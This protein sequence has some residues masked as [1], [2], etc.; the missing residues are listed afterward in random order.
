M[1][2]NYFPLLT[3]L[4]VWGPARVP[5]QPKVRPAPC[6]KATWARDPGGKR[7]GGPEQTLSL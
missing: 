6:P 3:G 4:R 5:L 2:A 7:L 1:S